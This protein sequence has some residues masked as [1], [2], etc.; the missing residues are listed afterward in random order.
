MEAVISALFEYVNAAFKGFLLTWQF[1]GCWKKP[2]G[3]EPSD[4]P[5][6]I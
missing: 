2:E 4:V 1:V 6:E 3:I 5:E